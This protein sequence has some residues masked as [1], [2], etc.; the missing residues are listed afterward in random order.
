[1][2]CCLIGLIFWSML[3]EDELTELMVDVDGL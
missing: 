2:G 1:M 3:V